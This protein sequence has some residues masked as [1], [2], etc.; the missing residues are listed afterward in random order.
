MSSSRA[1]RPRLDLAAGRVEMTHG[2]GGRAMAQLIEQVFFPAFACPELERGEDQAV[3][4]SPGTRLALTVDGHVVTP[5]FFPGGDIGSLSVYGTVNDLAVGGARPRHL[6]ASFVIEEGFP[7]ADLQRIALSMGEAARRC[8]VT[9]AAAD[10]KV[11]ERGSAD[12]VF[13]TTTGIGE[14]PEH[15]ELGT[16]TIRPG[17]QVLLSGPIGDHGIAI[18]GKRENVAFDAPVVSDS[19]P[20]HLLT[21]SLLEAVPG[22]VRAMRDATRGGLATIAN[23]YAHAAGVGFLLNEE[24][25]PIRPAVSAACELLGIDPLYVANEGRLVA[26]VASDAVDDALAAMRADPLGREAA[27]IG[28]VVVDEHRFVCLKTAF[29][30][31]RV[32]DW[33]AG[34][35]LPRIC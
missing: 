28:E 14:V 9:I 2:A 10:T 3:V 5:L 1:F 12:G 13:V 6:T 25:I 21:A 29:G 23:E 16:R 7:L 19:A 33:L 18:L 26:V 8:G 34:D 31:M 24:S 30:G 17:D 27:H 20:L 35:P 4:P 32:V 22:R 15:L 11:V